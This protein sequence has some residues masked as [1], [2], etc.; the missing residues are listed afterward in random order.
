MTVGLF[1]DTATAPAVRTPPRHAAARSVRRNAR[2]YG[3]ETWDP[4]GHLAAFVVARLRP[5]PAGLRAS[6]VIDAYHD[7][8]ESAGIDG[9]RLYPPGILISELG[10]RFDRVSIGQGLGAWIVGCRWAEAGP[11]ATGEEARR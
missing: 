3:P 10:K 6:D 2:D 9:E 5:G 11:D 4:G 8:A 7:W 1:D